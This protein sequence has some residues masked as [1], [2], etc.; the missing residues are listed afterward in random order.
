MF[1]FF[2]DA[3]AAA[4]SLETALHACVSEESDQNLMHTKKEM[5]RWH[6]RWGH[7]SMTLVKW[8]ARRGLP[9]HF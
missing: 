4:V 9:G 5:L 6:W 7:P 2:D 3:K 1:H 8:M